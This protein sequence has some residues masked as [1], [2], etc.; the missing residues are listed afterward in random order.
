MKVSIGNMKNFEEQEAEADPRQAFSSHK[1][2]ADPPIKVV[3]WFPS[4]VV[5]RSNQDEKPPA[6]K[7]HLAFLLPFTILAGLFG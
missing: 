1:S 3:D 2:S 6:A 4:S 5:K 7:M